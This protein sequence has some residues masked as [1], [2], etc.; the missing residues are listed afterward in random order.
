MGDAEFFQEFLG[1]AVVG[2]GEAE[3]RAE[4]RT[5]REKT[6]EDIR[7][8]SGILRECKMLEDTP[9]ALAELSRRMLASLAAAVGYLA[10]G[11]L[12]HTGETRQK[13]GFSCAG[14]AL[15]REKRPS[16][17]T[18]IESFQHRTALAL[19]AESVD[20]KLGIW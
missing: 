8:D 2:A 19:D 4:R 3:E 5:P 18:H 7:F 14:A 6:A 1:K 16:L 11:R 13:A 15:D 9:D 20:A 12:E 17:K 10:F